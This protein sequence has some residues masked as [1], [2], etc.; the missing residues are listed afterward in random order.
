MTVITIALLDK[1]RARAAKKAERAAGRPVKV[2][3]QSTYCKFCD[4]VMNRIP[5]QHEYV[6]CACVGTWSHR[7]GWEQGDI[8]YLENCA[9]GEY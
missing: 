6:C 5:A 4:H 2:S 8:D 3:G 9:A 7:H 1:A